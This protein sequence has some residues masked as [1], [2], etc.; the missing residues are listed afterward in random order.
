MLQQNNSEEKITVSVWF[1]DVDTSDVKS[2][3]M[4]VSGFLSRTP[5]LNLS[6]IK[7]AVDVHS[8]IQ[9]SRNIAKQIYQKQN[10]EFIQKYLTNADIIY[11]SR[12][13]PEV[14][15][16]A[17]KAEI[18]QLSKIKS[19][20]SIDYIAEDLMI[21]STQASD[22]Q[23]MISNAVVNVPAVHNSSA[24]GYTGIGVNIGI[25]D[26]GLPSDSVMSSLN[27]MAYLGNS[28]DAHAESTTKTLASVAPNA[29]YYFIG[30]TGSPNMRENIEWLLDQNVDIINIS[31]S[32]G[33][34][35]RN[36]YGNTARYIDHVA[37][38]HYVSVVIAAG[39]DELNGGSTGI[40]EGNMGYNSLTVG[41]INDKST[42]TL[43]DDEVEFFSRYYNGDTLCSKPDIGAPGRDGTSEASPRAA[44]I[45]A[46][47]C[48]AQ[49]NLLILPE[50][51]KSIV[52]ATT[53]KDSHLRY[54]PSQRAVNATLANSSYMQIGAGLIDAYAAVE[55]AVNGDYYNAML[56]PTV[57]SKSSSLPVSAAG[58]KV[59]VSLAF[60]QPI[61]LTNPSDHTQS[62]AT[63]G[64]FIDLDLELYAPDG[65]TQ[66][67]VSNTTFNNV[68]IVEF[69][70]P[71]AGTYTIRVSRLTAS[72]KQTWYGV[73]WMI[74]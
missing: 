52:T 42:L 41:S 24:Y 43:S 39:N 26:V 18:E 60:L 17:N 33:G 32:L 34:G 23:T 48:E 59:R 55:C 49:P 74:W 72:S 40:S 10:A 45:L 67:A 29:N 3:A 13:A 64:D 1:A 50:V 31:M 25:Y 58:K 8:F 15:I 66:I 19:V 16:R 36:Q 38:I 22:T 65:V 5:E 9:T 28:S 11:V 27:T 12:Y 6:N 2:L 63:A 69:T 30:D 62:E 53:N 46:L 7:T 20:E 57:L 68:E 37:Y 47:L 51:Q 4:R 44:G 35:S 73:A 56:N 61:T 71:A 14:I 21:S 70:A 54:V